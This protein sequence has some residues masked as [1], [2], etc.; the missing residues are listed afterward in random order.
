M[1]DIKSSTL[2]YLQHFLVHRK[3]SIYHI[4]IHKIFYFTISDSLFNKDF[5]S[6]NYFILIY[7]VRARHKV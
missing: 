2:A 6:N 7:Y 3:L 5:N 4:K 1:Y